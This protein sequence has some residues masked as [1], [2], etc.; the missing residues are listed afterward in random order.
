[1]PRTGGSG[2]QVVEGAVGLADGVTDA[3]ARVTCRVDPEAA[4]VADVL[5]S[6]DP[7]ADLAVLTG[8]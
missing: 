8:S 4:V 6:G 2:D 1:M 7:L 5:E 3:L